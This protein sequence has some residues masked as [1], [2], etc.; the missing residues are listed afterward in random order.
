MSLKTEMPLDNDGDVRIFQRETGSDTLQ[1]RVIAHYGY[2]SDFL[3]HAIL[4]LLQTG[5]QVPYRKDWNQRFYNSLFQKPDEIPVEI[6]S[7]WTINRRV[8]EKNLVR[9]LQRPG[10]TDEQSRNVFAFQDTIFSEDVFPVINSDGNLVYL[11]PAGKARLL[12]DSEGVVDFH[13]QL[14]AQLCANPRGQRKEIG[15][16]YSYFPFKAYEKEFP[17]TKT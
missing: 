10:G 5:K 4:F 6:L 17:K 14:L 1:Y 16:V 8:E 9:L 7:L 13:R 12:F 11:N 15:I 3:V 2:R